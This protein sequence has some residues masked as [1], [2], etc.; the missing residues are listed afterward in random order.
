MTKLIKIWGRDDNSSSNNDIN[1]KENS[2]IPGGR[3]AS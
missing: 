1:N 2:E 3:L